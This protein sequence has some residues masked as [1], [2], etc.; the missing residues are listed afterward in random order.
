MDEQAKP[1]TKIEGRVVWEDECQGAL[2][3]L[4]ELIEPRIVG[5]GARP[6]RLW[7]EGR[8][9]VGGQWHYTIEG[10][11]AEATRR[12]DYDLYAQITRLRLR[13]INLERQ[14]YEATK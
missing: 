8:P 13:V 1:S 5:A 6:Y 12:S 3:Q 9:A 4:E 10:A 11:K 14:L 2:F 7:C